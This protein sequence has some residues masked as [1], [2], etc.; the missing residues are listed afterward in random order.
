M[1][2]QYDALIQD[3][4]LTSGLFTPHFANIEKSA[5]VGHGPSIVNIDGSTPLV[6]PN[7]IP[8][9]THV[10]TMF[11]YYDYMEQFCKDLYERDALTI[12]GIDWGLEVDTNGVKIGHDGQEQKMPVQTRRTQLNPVFTWQEK[13][14]SPIWNFHETWI[15]MFKNPDTQGSLTGSAITQSGDD[16][17]PLLY[18]TFCM[19]ILWIQPDTTLRPGSVLRGFFTVAMFPT[20]TGSYGFKKE[21]GGNQQMMQRSVTFECVLQEDRKTTEFAQTVANILRLQEVDFEIATPATEQI[22]DRLLNMGYQAEIQRAL[23]TFNPLN[24]GNFIYTP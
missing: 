11:K 21:A 5:Q 8:I 2:V 24:R 14:G 15:K 22:A 1:P 18:S 4:E 13:V 19:D 10:P 12:E 3:F 9:V 20:G 6:L 17:L 16:I 7:I 23:E